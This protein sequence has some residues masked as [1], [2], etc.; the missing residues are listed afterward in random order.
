[1]RPADAQ[2]H[3]MRHPRCAGVVDDGLPSW[4]GQNVN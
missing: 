4:A 3:S 1:M 2:N